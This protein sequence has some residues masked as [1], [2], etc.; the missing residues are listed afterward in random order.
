MKRLIDRG[1]S[2]L[3]IEM[4]GMIGNVLNDD[5]VLEIQQEKGAAE[6][7]HPAP[8]KKPQRSVHGSVK[9]A[10]KWVSADWVWILGGITALVLF[11]ALIAVIVIVVTQNQQTSYCLQTT[12]GV[13]GLSAVSLGSDVCNREEYT[14][15]DLSSLSSLRTVTI[16]D[17]DFMHVNTV[18][19]SNLLLLESVVIGDN[20]F[21]KNGYGNSPDGRFQLKNCPALKTLRMGS[22]AFKDYNEWIVDS[23][24]ALEGSEI[25]E[26]RFSSVQSF[27]IKTGRRACEL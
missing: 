12:K 19:I 26:N 13:T 10:R 5:A 8:E 24:N 22:N 20:S 21:W 2:S 11:P 27:D 1:N 6:N 9:N 7:P 17:R 3:L 25:R 16:G 14:S 4:S 15:L 18:T 23:V